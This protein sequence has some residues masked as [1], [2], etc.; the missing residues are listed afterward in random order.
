MS[1][2]IPFFLRSQKISRTKLLYSSEARIRG[3]DERIESVGQRSHT[4]KVCQLLGAG[5]LCDIEEETHHRVRYTDNRQMCIF[6]CALVYHG[7]N[8]D[9]IGESLQLRCVQQFLSPITLGSIH[10][11]IHQFSSGGG[12][13]S[14]FIFQTIIDIPSVYIYFTSS[15]VS[16]HLFVYIQRTIAF[17]SFRLGS[18]HQRSRD[19]L[20]VETFLFFSFI[21]LRLAADVRTKKKKETY[22]PLLFGGNLIDVALKVSSRP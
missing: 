7:G 14:P 1:P 6:F 12:G 5:A 16:C 18:H 11:N 9:D 17:P 19:R 2:Y 15:L 22:I 21:L 8:K 13:R 3:N 4:I 10:E 20:R